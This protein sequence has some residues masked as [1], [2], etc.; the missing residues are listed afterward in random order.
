MLNLQTF[1]ERT[2]LKQANMGFAKED[3]RKLQETGLTTFTRT[4]AGA[5]LT[6]KGRGSSDMTE[7]QRR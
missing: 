3:A 6:Y 1:K 2:V 7:F 5:K 4:W